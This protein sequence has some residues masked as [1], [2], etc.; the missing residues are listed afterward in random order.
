MENGPVFYNDDFRRAI[1][2]ARLAR[3]WTQSQLAEHIGS[4]LDAVKKWEAGTRGF[5]CF[6]RQRLCET[7]GL[8]L[9]AFGRAEQPPATKDALAEKAVLR[10]R[11]PGDQRDQL[12]RQV[13]LTRLTLTWIEGVLHQK[14]KAAKLLHLSLEAQPALLA[15][16]WVLDVP[17][18]QLPAHPLPAATSLVELYDQTEGGLL[19]VGEGGA[20]KT[21]LT[22][23]LL[24]VLLTRA[25]QREDQRVPFFFPLT[26]WATR[27]APLAEWLV[28][29]MET[30]YGVVRS[31]GQAWLE[32]NRVI[33]LLDGLDEI[34]PARREACVTAINAYQRVSPTPLVLNCR[35]KDYTDLAVRAELYTAVMVQP[36]SDAQITEYLAAASISHH[37]AHT[38][39][40]DDPGLLEMVRSPLM[41]SIITQLSREKVET[42]II[43]TG[44]PD[45]R[46]KQVLERYVRH[47]F[48]RRKARCYT[49]ERT[50]HWLASLARHMQEHH[51][52]EFHLER[53]Q[54]AWL[55]E[56][57]VRTGYQHT[58]I[59]LIYGLQISLVGMLFAW[60]RGGLRPGTVSGISNG[61]FGLF[62]A[63]PGNSLLS[64]MAQGFGGGIEGG[65]SFCLLLTLVFILLPLLLGTQEHPPLTMQTIKQG[66]LK[67][68]NSGLKL[69]VLLSM[70]SI[71]LFSVQRG[72]A[73][74][75]QYGLGAA[76]FCGLVLGLTTSVIATLGDAP[77]S[78]LHAQ[79]R[80]SLLIDAGVVSICAGICFGLVDLA[81]H[82]VLSSILIYS[83]I[84][85]VYFWLALTMGNALHLL[86]GVGSEIH[87]T[88]SVSWALGSI[89]PVFAQ[90][91]IKGMLLGLVLTVSMSLV[92][93]SCSALFYGW[94]YAVHYGL[95]YGLVIG[96]SGGVVSVLG[97]LLNTVWVSDLLD[98]KHLCCPNEGIRRTLRNAFLAA[99]ICGPLGGLVS[100]FL[101][102]MVFGWVG[103]LAGWGI[104]TSGLMLVWTI[105]FAVEFWLIYG[106]QAWLQHYLLRVALWRS[107]VMPLD[108]VAFLDFAAERLLLY[109]VRGG[110][111]FSHRLV[112]DYFAALPTEEQAAPAEGDAPTL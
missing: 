60:M 25:S 111:I 94:R 28:E 13:A 76:L 82:L 71:P 61:L 64:W 47:A 99:L 69:V 85:T 105:L 65:G 87:P 79:G 33:L 93:A 31:I 59:R 80:F 40:R 20:G 67:G 45:E 44:T 72:L 6:F 102:G 58:A 37:E 90:K 98:P 15:N 17:E 14:V 89:R 7:L 57:R 63:G 78:T 3:S 55:P 22:L 26:S 49:W 104:L 103:G 43:F 66:L 27:Q 50:Q 106:G 83:S 32:Q 108:V 81:L 5:S 96:L 34:D 4:S 48:E 24:R 68:V 112:A 52:V 42:D 110:Y 77:S 101:S 73:H 56:G 1:K 35:I 23:E 30:R 18:T 8:D 95:M 38:A 100:G 75:L 41:L 11:S 36:L 19:L 70:V 74:G 91:L 29:E 62:G 12:N 92:L 9:A 21:T 10:E 16:P 2:H 53:I 39:L 54:P 107:G 109:K 84:A 97:S 51:Q 46:R 88:E 86:R